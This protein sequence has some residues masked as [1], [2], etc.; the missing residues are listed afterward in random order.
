MKIEKFEVAPDVSVGRPAIYPFKDLLPNTRFSVEID[1]EEDAKKKL[2]SVYY[3]LRQYKKTN[4]VN[5]ETKVVLE[6]AG[7]DNP[8]KKE[9]VVY[10][11]S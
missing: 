9:V 3:A 1:D 11:I 8:E 5:W 7:G 10:R 2:A 4:D 6:V